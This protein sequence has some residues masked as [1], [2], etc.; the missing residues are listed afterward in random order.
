MRL[1]V[2]S[3]TYNWS[4]G[5][6]GFPQP[7]QPLT[8]EALLQKA[9]DLGVQVVQIADNLPLHALS[10]TQI[11]SLANRATQL[12]IAIEVGTAGIEPDHLQTYLNLALRL[13]SPLV[14]V[15]IDT[16][17]SQPTLDEIV[18]S[19]HQS[20][21]AFTA[22]GVWLAIENHDRLPAASLAHI[23]ERCRGHHLGIC[24][25]TANSLG[26]GEDISTLLRTLGPWIINVH[27]K[28][29]CPRRLPHKKGFIIE[30]C[31]AGSG[32]LDIPHLLSDISH[33]GRD[34]NIV[35]ELWQSPDATID[36]TIAK[37]DAW[38]N[39][40]LHYLRQYIAQ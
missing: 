36:Q 13:R 9:A 29:Y 30:G 15:V 28:D 37:E 8:A 23:I 3:Y 1:G 39:Q 21:P 11:D 5:V 19:L 18:D 31:P 38:A 17:S 34:P 25:D 22:A 4:V 27:I 33:F 35:L 26:C 6:P 20:L 7:A 16:E 12:A 24:L 32:V 10:A 2:S 14:R 40:S